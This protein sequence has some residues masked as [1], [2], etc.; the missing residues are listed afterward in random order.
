ME[1]LDEMKNCG[2]GGWDI[3]TELTEGAVDGTVRRTV[4]V[5]GSLSDE[6]QTK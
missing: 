4:P 2:A 6:D 3:D 1:I 5:N